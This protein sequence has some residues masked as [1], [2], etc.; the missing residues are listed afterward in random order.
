[1]TEVVVVGPLPPPL[2]GAAKITAQMRDLMVQR[3]LAVRSLTTA[4]PG[5]AAHTRSLGYHLARLRVFLRNA[6]GLGRR[7]P[8][9]LVPDGG[10][11]IAYTYGYVRLMALT[12]RT[13]ILHH[14]NY[15]H[16][17]VPSRLMAGV[18]RVLPQATH[19]FL[20]SVMGQGFDHAY[21]VTTQKF[22]IDNA[23][24]NDVEF[25]DGDTPS[26]SEERRQTIG[27]LSNLTVEKGFDTVV[28]VFI[29]LATARPELR[30][31]LAGKPASAVEEALLEQL[32]QALGLRLDYRGAVYGEQKTRF[33]ADIGAFVFPTKYRQEAQPNVIYEALATGC[34]VVATQRACL[35]EML[36]RFPSAVVAEGPNFDVDIE[37]ALLA[38]IEAWTPA[39]HAEIVATYSDR[40]GESRT[41]LETFMMWLAGLISD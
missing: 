30:F 37:A 9:Y 10:M 39:V 3:G 21:G 31:V 27:Y 18:V 1:M 20:D 32:K 34:Y 40:L 7:G 35:P 25:A 13:A 28:A 16:I 22:V 33:F 11:G 12:G 14:H 41:E 36:R 24:W 4:S 38:G 19:V 5:A 6:M 8:V 15:S 2:T 23:V 17:D 26:W 29:A